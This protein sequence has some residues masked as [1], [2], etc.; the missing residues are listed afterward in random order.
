MRKSRY[1][2]YYIGFILNG[3][4]LGERRV[5]S[6]NEPSLAENDIKN[7]FEKQGTRYGFIFGNYR[8]LTDIVDERLENI[9]FVGIK[10]RPFKISDFKK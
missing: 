5:W 6:I 4:I 2:H 1:N 8:C 7:H 3:K 9:K 10:N